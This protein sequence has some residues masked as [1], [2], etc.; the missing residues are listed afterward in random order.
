MLDSLQIF[1]PY[2]T[3]IN[4]TF[5]LGFNRGDFIVAA[6]PTYGEIGLLIAHDDPQNGT[7]PQCYK[8]CSGCAVSCSGYTWF[9]P[10]FGASPV[11]YIPG[12]NPCNPIVPP[13]APPVIVNPNCDPNLSYRPGRYWAVLYGFDTI[14]EASLVAVQPGLPVTLADGQPQD[15][16]TGPVT[17]CPRRDNVTGVCS[18]PMFPWILNVQ[19]AY[20]T[21]RIPVTEASRDSYIILDRLCNN[22]TGYCGPQLHA[23]V[24]ACRDS[25]PGACD[26][27][28]QYPS[29]SNFRTDIVVSDVQ[30]SIH[31][32][33]GMCGGFGVGDCI[34][35]VG[36]YPICDGNV[37]P[38]VNCQPALVR[39]T[40][41]TD[42]GIERISQDCFGVGRTCVLPEENGQSGGI[43][44]YMADPGNMPT[45]LVAQATVCSGTLNLYYC[46][47]FNGNCNPVNMPGPSNNDQQAG[48]DLH[49]FATISLNVGGGIFFLGVRPSA[50]GVTPSYQLSLQAGSGPTL[51][52]S[53][54]FPNVAATRSG[55]SIIVSWDYPYISA[56]GQL[57]YPVQGAQYVI[58]AFP[59]GTTGQA[60]P[61]TPCGVDDAIATTAGVIQGSTQGQQYVLTVNAALTYTVSVVA[62]CPAG[63]CMP[64]GQ[65]AQRVAF[66]PATSGPAAAS[67]SPSASPQPYT[68]APAG[69]GGLSTGGA[70]AVAVVVLLGVGVGGFFGYRRFSGAG[71][72]SLPSIGGG[73]GGG[74]INLAW[75][76]PMNWFG[77]R[78][79]YDGYALASSSGGLFT[80]DGMDSFDT[81]VDLQ[82]EG[83]GAAYTAL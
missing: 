4:F 65:M 83:Q 38:G 40:L 1:V 11:L 54:Q 67:P 50:Q 68:P 41:S 27:N 44:R 25:G 36:V 34:I 29:A 76:N 10:S 8:P 32:T 74:G 42:T 7:I 24:M 57:S 78:N 66:Y 22:M 31:V 18:G 35:T 23:Y 72:G 46:D 59:Q 28:G 12:G 63:T 15:L 5:T 55:S 37:Q 33:Y 69:K 6:T 21:L 47:A 48:P 61:D 9:M 62:T 19:A 53:P 17:L 80:S 2:N 71:G 51:V 75:L 30:A 82:N 13:G 60:R 49:G 14:S 20:F 52:V 81:G 43:K 3:N 26:S 64:N 45:T 70:A 77:N 39:A 73:G 79:S 58:A 56:P 16:Q